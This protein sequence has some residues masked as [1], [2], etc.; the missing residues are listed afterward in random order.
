MYYYKQLLADD[1]F[2]LI[3]SV[4]TVSGKTEISK[5]E[6]EKLLNDMEKKNSEA[7]EKSMIEADEDLNE[8][9]LDSLQEE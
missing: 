2:I 5:E 7:A 6:Y 1:N 4:K 9:R 3:E 8:S